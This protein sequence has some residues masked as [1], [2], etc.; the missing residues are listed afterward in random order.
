MAQNTPTYLYCS[1]AK[2]VRDNGSYNVYTK[3]PS[4]TYSCAD[5]IESA[6]AM[7]STVTETRIIGVWYFKDSKCGI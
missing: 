5:K 2:I 3:P 1:I 7:S 4:Y 6:L